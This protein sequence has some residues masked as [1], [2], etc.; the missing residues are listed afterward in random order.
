MKI[1][2]TVEFYEPRKGGVEEVVKQIA[3]HLV[4][5]GHDVVVATSFDKERDF[6]RLEGV[7]IEV[8]HLSGNSVRGIKGGDKEKKR[9]QD[10]L[11]DGDFDV[12]VNY[13]AQIWHSDL[14]FDVLNRIRAKKVFI[15]VGYSKLADASYGE[16]YKNLP[17][18]L[19]KID[20]LIHHSSSYQDKQFDDEHGFEE[21]GIVIPNGASE[22][23]FLGPSFVDVRKKFNIKTSYSVLSVSNHYKAKGHSFVIS[24]F[25]KMKRKDTTLIIVGGRFVSSGWRRL[26]H[27]VLDY[28][29]CWMASIFNSRI[30][31]VDGAERN[32]V[33]ALYREADLF[34]FGSQV[35]CAP[36]VMYESFA[37]L[38]P[39]ITTPVGNVR[40]YQDIVTIILTPKEMAHKANTFLDNKVERDN[41]AKRAF[42]IWQHDHTWGNI[43]E[44]YE[45]LFKKLIYEES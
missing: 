9:Y 24:A 32:D 36:L 23:E 7:L 37:S 20:A 8:F 13:A 34:L 29:F 45:R 40:D 5:K 21:K 27:F 15:P 33:V 17:S 11:V 43:A 28:L 22:E 39:F 2:F 26:A 18:H 14:M 6:S 3:E 12:I 44:M 25:K 4:Q 30:I 38:T 42:E 16:Y 41:V 10:M 19:M 35:E 1:L 31:L